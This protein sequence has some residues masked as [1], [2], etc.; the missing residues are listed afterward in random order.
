MSL[1]QYKAIDRSGRQMQS[2]IE[3]HS[4]TSARDLLSQRGIFVQTISTDPTRGQSQAPQP[5]SKTSSLTLRDSDRAEFI[6]QLA[7][8]LK[9]QLPLLT[10]LEV[11]GRQN[12]LP[13]VKQ[14][15]AELIGKIKSGQSL[16]LAFSQYPKIFNTLHLSMVEVGESAGILDESLLQLAT[17]VEHELET[18]GEIMTASLYPAFVLCLGIISVAVVVTWILPQILA[19]LAGDIDVLPLPTRV[20]YA[21]NLFLQSYWWVLLGGTLIVYLMIRSWKKTSMGR[22]FLDGL[23]LKSPFLG[24]LQQKWAVARFA[25]TLGVLPQGGVD[26][27]DALQIVRNTL[28]NEVLARQIDQVASQVRK[29]SSLAAPL[30]ESGRFPPL[31]V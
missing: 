31:L 1:F 10:A 9:A 23:K 20:I 30:R 7:T 12:P 15:S 22:L 5:A 18:R 24:P 16:S 21:T 3:A 8:S 14:L 13:K 4:E 25:R 11:V 17:L 19:T 29:G 6:R 28:G 27:L 26:I 2:E